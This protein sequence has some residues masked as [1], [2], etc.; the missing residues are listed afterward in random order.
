V[1][2]DPQSVTYATVA[3]SLPA[4]GRGEAQ[5]E[6]KLVDS[7]VVYDLILGHQ[8]KA[9]TRVFARLRRDSSVSDPLVP[10]NSIPA[11]M[12]AS[13]TLDFPNAGLTPTDA[14]ALA[15]ALVAWASDANLLKLASGE[16]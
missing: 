13:L 14:Q 11:S 6:Y 12:T 16:T 15:K 10:A 7:G 2:S 3:K 5:S 9:R 4:I 1:F 8:F